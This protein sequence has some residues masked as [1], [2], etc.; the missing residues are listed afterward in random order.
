[1]M[2]SYRLLIRQSSPGLNANERGVLR[3]SAWA[4]SG[5]EGGRSAALHACTRRLSG[6][7]RDGKAEPSSDAEAFAFEM[8]IARDDDDDR[9]QDAAR[10]V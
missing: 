4:D 6:Q 9:R 1:M 3:T 5:V 7:T 8:K 2:T 10:R